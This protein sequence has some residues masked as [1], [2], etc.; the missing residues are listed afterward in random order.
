MNET[1]TLVDDVLLKQLSLETKK[2]GTHVLIKRTPHHP[3]FVADILDVIILPH[4][5]FYRSKYMMYYK[6]CNYNSVKA[7]KELARHF[8]FIPDFDL[9]IAFVLNI[10]TN[11]RNF[12]DA[13]KIAKELEFFNKPMTGVELQEV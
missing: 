4:S 7:L 3:E 2:I 6:S 13:I 12:S 10:T 11:E 8:P 5:E 9:G 1:K